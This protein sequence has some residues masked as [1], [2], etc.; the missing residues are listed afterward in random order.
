MKEEVQH[1]LNANKIALAEINNEIDQI[2]QIL[3]TN[4]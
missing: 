2:K 4:N 1:I 3:N